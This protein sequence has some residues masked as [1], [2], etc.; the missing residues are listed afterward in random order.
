MSHSKLLFYQAQSNSDM[1]TVA[2][3]VVASNRTIVL[4]KK[5][6]TTH[7]LLLFITTTYHFGLGSL[8]IFTFYRPAWSINLT[9]P[10]KLCF[11]DFQ[12]QL[13]LMEGGS[14]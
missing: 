1:C 12:Q 8:T 4:W 10:S 13:K 3:E 14:F 7:S 9:R 5:P 6:T 11:T 2:K